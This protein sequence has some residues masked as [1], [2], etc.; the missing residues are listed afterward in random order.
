METGWRLSEITPVCV[1]IPP[2]PLQ[3]RLR[4][5]AHQEFPGNSRLSLQSCQRLFSTLRRDL[6]PLG[7]F[8]RRLGVTLLLGPLPGTRKLG[9]EFGE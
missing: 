8:L 3:P 6:Q 2:L 7:D 4:N 9:V 1:G 5:L